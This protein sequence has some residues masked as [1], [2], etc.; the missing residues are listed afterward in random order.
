MDIFR[1]AD[2]HRMPRNSVVTIGMFDGV[3]RGHREVI[4]SLLDMAEDRGCEALVIT[5]DR[6]PRLVLGKETDDFRLLNTCAE[7]YGMME[8]LGIRN[9]MEIAFDH[10]VAMLSACEF[11]KEFLVGKL[12]AKALLLG[13][14]NMFGN[15]MVNDFGRIPGLAKSEN[16][17][18]FNEGPVMLDGVEISSTEIRKALK[19]GDVARANAMLG[20]DYPFSGKVVEGRRV[21]HTFGYPTANIECADKMKM[22]PADGVYCT[23]LNIG[24]KQ[25]PSMTNVGSQPTFGCGKRTCETHILDFEGDIYGKEAEVVFL[26]RIREVWRFDTPQQLVN[27]LDMDKGFCRRFF[28]ERRNAK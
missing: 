17:E 9:V 28:E 4:K 16:V 10:E 18:V 27:Q 14:D 11:F 23:L 3:H 24:G 5:F 7:R 19:A 20:Y 2:F 6:H 8:A 15:K 25:F 13:Y 1:T 22:L 21:G 12:S 26:E